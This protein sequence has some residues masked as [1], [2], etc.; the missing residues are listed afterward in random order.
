MGRV[1]APPANAAGSAPHAPAN[2][3]AT[4]SAI[5][6][7]RDGH[8]IGSDMRNRPFQLAGRAPEREGRRHPTER[9]FDT[10]RRIPSNLRR[11]KR[12]PPPGGLRKR[13]AWSGRPVSYTH[14]RAHETRHDL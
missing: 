8:L 14:L 4:N 7:G 12:R 10:Q 6:S 13:F 5:N 11:K 2:I 9:M 3:T 1:H